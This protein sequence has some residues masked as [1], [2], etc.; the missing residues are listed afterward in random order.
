MTKVATELLVSG[1]MPDTALVAR[2][3]SGDRAAQNA[4]VERYYDDCWRYAF[5]LLGERADA[6][7][8]VQETFMRAMAALP[9]YQDHERF[10]GW[11]FTI[12]V[13]QCRNLATSR[14][15]RALRFAPLPEERNAP[16]LAMV[17]PTEL[18]DDEVAMALAELDPSQ[19][20]II[21]LKFGEGLGYGD[22][23]R[24]TGASESALK[25]RVKRALARMRAFIER[26][27]RY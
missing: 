5:R 11:L 27:E 2:A 20:E 21:L 3:R 17:P 18:A 7:D 4:L 13:N 22:I 1:G 9:R 24:L 8:A 14:K 6:E 15:R 16:P 19:R 25:M 26:H 23:A 10:R 12:L